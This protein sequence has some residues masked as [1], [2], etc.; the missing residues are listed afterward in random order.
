MGQFAQFSLADQPNGEARISNYACELEVQGP[1][2]L[3]PRQCVRNYDLVAE[4][5]DFTSEL[6]VGGP[7]FG[8]H[9]TAD[10]WYDAQYDKEA[11]DNLHLT[12]DPALAAAKYLTIHSPKNGEGE[13]DLRDLFLYGRTDIFGDEPLAVR[14]GRHALLWGESLFFTRDAIAGA[15]APVDGYLYQ[16]T[17]TTYGASTAFLPVAQISAS[18]QPVNGLAVDLYYQAEWRRSEVVP[19]DAYSSA[20]DVLGA[21][22]E[23]EIGL[24]IPNAAGVRIPTLF[25]RA[26][27]QTPGSTDQF[28]AAFKLQRGEVDYGLYGLS[29]N[30]TLPALYFRAPSVSG[31]VGSYTLE[32]PKGIDLIGAS[33][34]APLGAGTLGGEISGRWNMPLVTGGVLV[35]PGVQ[36]DNGAHPLYPVGNTLAAQLSWTYETPPLPWIPGGAHWSTEIAGNDRLAVTAGQA[37]LAPDR[38][39]AAMALRTVFEPQFFQVLPRLDL[40][41]PIGLGINFLGLSSVDWP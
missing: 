6:N 11:G 12:L 14:F 25:T 33:L 34:S 27:D 18:W 16:S 32:Y 38:T 20:S 37:A 4:R 2:L 21:D 22:N 30:A 24:S 5:G 31:G 15:Q 29:Y 39:R 17:S 26:L 36:A 7:D 10:I 19:Y 23:R 1:A 40:T 13:F 9:A 28:G 3:S 41:L 8:L 35:P